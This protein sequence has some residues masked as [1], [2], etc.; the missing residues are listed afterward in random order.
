M[1]YKSTEEVIK[2]G[3]KTAV[4]FSKFVFDRVFYCSLGISRSNVKC[5]KAESNLK[6]VSDN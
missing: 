2:T 3:S 4:D 1:E 6:L 5:R